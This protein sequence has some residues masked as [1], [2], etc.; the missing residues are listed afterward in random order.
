LVDQLDIPEQIRPFLTAQVSDFLNNGVWFIP[1]ALSTM[2]S[3]LS[4]II[5]K[6]SL[7]LETTHDKFIWKHTDNGELELKQAYEFILPQVQDLHWAKL[8]WNVDIPPS[9][10]FLVWRLM[11]GKLPT[12]ENL[13]TRGCAMPSMCNFCHKH[14]E[15][16]FH[17]FF[18]CYF[19]IKLWSW[20]A[21]C[22]NLTLQFTSM[23]DIWKLCDLSW[24][25]QSKVTIIVAIINLLNTI[26]LVR[27]KARFDDTNITWVA[28]ISKIISSTAMSGN[29]TKKL[30]S[31]SIRDF[32]FLKCFNIHIHQP[33]T[34]FTKEVYWHPPLM[35]WVKCNIDGASNGNPGN[36]ACGGIYRDHNADFIYGFAEPLGVASAYIAEM[37]G[38]MRAI[39]TAYHNQWNNLWLESDSTTVVEAF[40]NLD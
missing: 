25:P 40:N 23:E 5:S 34:T 14:V 26:W 6:V 15:S 9:K 32:T 29:N 17:I 37:C 33:R 2:F 21:G 39:E 27:N 3:N 22:L 4:S 8:I 16:S 7:P 35:N 10:S 20:L 31:N 38:A 1:P 19:A 18:E 12:D 30:A 13:M 36:A 28:A 11:H 24:A